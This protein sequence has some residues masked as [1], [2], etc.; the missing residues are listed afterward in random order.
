MSK[1]NLA[2]YQSSRGARAGL[3]VGDKIIDVADATGNAGDVS[4]LG[5]VENWEAGL[6]RLDAAAEKGLVSAKPLSSVTL[7][8]PIP[9]PMAIYCAGANYR[10]HANE[11]A[12]VQ[13]KPEPVDPHTLGLRSWHFLKV[14]HCVTGPATTVQ[15]PVKTKKLDWEVELALV[16]GKTARNVAEKDALDYVMGYTIANDLSAR[17]LGTRAGLPDNS[18]FRAD[19]VSHKCFDGSCPMGPWITLA[20]DIGNPHDLK[21][22]LDVNGAVKQ[23]SNSKEL[24]FN[25]NEQIADISSRITLYPGDVILTGTPAGVGA[26]KGEFLKSGDKVRC[27]V[28]KIGEIVNTMA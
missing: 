4:V 12:K 3:V 23:N 24:I 2:T 25:I 14:G 11:M 19:W 22:G 26:G 15:I 8:A 10:D 9:R 7:L 18:N 13:G 5:I 17:D 28:E 6:K 20:R 21:L 16:I 1:F 27:W